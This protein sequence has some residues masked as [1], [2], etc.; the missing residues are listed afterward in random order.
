MSYRALVTIT[1]NNAIISTGA[2]ERSSMVFLGDTWGEGESL[3]ELLGQERT[4]NLALKALCGCN[5]EGRS[6]AKEFADV[7]H[8]QDWTSRMADE[9]WAVEFTLTGEDTL[10]TVTGLDAGGTV[11]FYRRTL[12]G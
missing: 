10:V 11:I 4:F 9:T 7:E 8:R 3:A 1:D 12:R 6:H 2:F 5:N